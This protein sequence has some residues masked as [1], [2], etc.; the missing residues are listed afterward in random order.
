MRVRSGKELTTAMERTP[1]EA[2]GV[3]GSGSD[4][5]GLQVGIH[6]GLCNIRVRKHQVLSQD[7]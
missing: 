2:Q 6:T 3:R 7:L 4:K 5:Y 1:H